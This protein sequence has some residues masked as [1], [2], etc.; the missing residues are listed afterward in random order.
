[1]LGG[2]QLATKAGRKAL[3]NASNSPIVLQSTQL[4]ALVPT[5]LCPAI[6][7][8]LPRGTVLPS[9]GPSSSSCSSSRLYS[10]SRSYDTI[11]S[12]IVGNRSASSLS[13]SDRRSYYFQAAAVTRPEYA[14]TNE[15][16]MPQRGQSQLWQGARGEAHQ[17]QG[18]SR[19]DPEE[20][21]RFA[22]ASLSDWRR[23]FPSTQWRREMDF[24]RYSPPLRRSHLPE[25]APA[26]YEDEVKAS[27]AWLPDSRWT[28]RLP[29]DYPV[30][31]ELFLVLDSLDDISQSASDPDCAGLL[32]ETLRQARELIWS[33]PEHPLRRRGEREAALYLAGK[34][35]ETFIKLD[36]EDSLNR[37]MTFLEYVRTQIGVLPLSCFHALAARSGIAR[38]Y[39][40]MLKICQV[41]QEHHSGKA[42]AELLHLR[43]RALIAQS[44]DVDLTRHWDHFSD[45][46]VSVPRKTFDLLLR[47]HVRRQDI[48]QVNEVLEAMP[49]HGHEVD[50]KA[51]LTIL[52]GFQ[53][54][55]PTLATMLRRDAKIVH[56]PTLNVVNRLLV[57]LSK[58][59]DV[60]GAMMVMRI[61]RIPSIRMRNET[62]A[63]SST[64]GTEMLIVNG[65]SPEPNVETYAIMTE[66][67]G[68]LGRIYE[69]RSFFRLA[70]SLCSEEAHADAFVEKALQQ[71]SRWVMYAFLNA[72]HPVRAMAFAAEVFSLPYF[73]MDEGKAAPVIQFDLPQTLSNIKLTATTVHYRTLLECASAIGSAKTARRIIVY[74][75]EQGHEIDKEVLCG[76]ARL[77]FSTIDKDAIKSIRFIQRLLPQGENSPK[78]K[79]VQ[80]LESLSD[81]LQHLGTP[82]K[83]ILASQ[84]STDLSRRNWDNVGTKAKRS[85]KAKCSTTV[86]SNTATTGKIAIS[87]KDGLRDWLIEDSRSSSLFRGF[88]PADD[89]GQDSRPAISHDLSRPLSSA[90][91]AIR[92]RVYA[93]VRRDYE[94]AQKVYHAM[95]AHNVKPTMMHIAPLIEGYT[96]VGKLNEAQ[97]LKRNAKEITGFQP[98]LRIHTA[99]IRAYIRAGDS[100]SARK[101]IQE[102]TD[103]GYEIDDAI[104]NIIEA[105]Q[106]GRGN[107]PLVE[108]P[109]DPKDC[110][111]VTTRFHALMRMRRYLAAQELIQSALDSG[112]RPDKVLYDLVRR[113][114]SYVEKEFAKALGQRKEATALRRANRACQP[115]RK[116]AAPQPAVTQ[117]ES[118]IRAHFYELTQAKR[119]ATV[120]KARIRKEGQPKS[121]VGGNRMKKHRKK[122]I[123]LVMEFADGKL[124][125]LARQKRK[126]R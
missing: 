55:R 49:Q 65:P 104:A 112:M 56:S 98:T 113:S 72:G 50:A 40:A 58:E 34:I 45:A 89:A 62:T 119:L 68:R 66:M 2:R 92:I 42:D 75:L 36:A 44:N 17:Q 54:F 33:N 16:S 24:N 53:S 73:N 22:P 74:V 99:L 107:F 47:T 111:S 79:R 28:L 117:T 37:L 85:T 61:F 76:L 39:D 122:V 48:A 100:T 120:N 114:V 94:S 6:E 69:A 80:R 60:D 126:E 110:H 93:V 25:D 15:H 5:F 38:R 14:S 4:D 81:M 84:H 118:E 35:A 46:D 13:S 10:S 18:T 90:A 96:A 21:I 9:V 87:T 83:V 8:R 29:D 12:A 70:L 64:E 31:H 108:R 43:L 51:W 59:L 125:K 41:A 52:R 19:I 32:T 106:M 82:D 27:A 88:M 1:M 11:R 3:R 26:L 102:L 124:H 7:L 105:G 78:S 121:E 109:I 71:A 30:R 116:G 20:L 67:F 123:S 95:L 23:K 103:N 57:L 97:Q 91:Y 86:Q 77:I 63:G 101:E 115:S